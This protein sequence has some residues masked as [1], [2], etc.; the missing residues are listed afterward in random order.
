MATPASLNVSLMKL[1]ATC[2]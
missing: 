2:L 1:V